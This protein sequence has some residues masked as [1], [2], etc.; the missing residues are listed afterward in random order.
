MKKTILLI[1]VFATLG[2]GVALAEHP[3]EHPAQ[4]AIGDSWFDLE[5]CGMCKNLHNDEEL[6]ENMQW[7]TKLFAQ[8]LIEVTTVPAAYEDR[9]DKLMA[10]MEATGA[11]LM[12]GEKIPLCGMC[13]SYGGLMMAGASMEQMQVGEAH[14]SVISS[15][16]P[17]VI[18]K[19]R[20]H[21]E[22]TIEEMKKWMSEGH[23]NDHGHD[24]HH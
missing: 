7:D 15:A 5:N 12:A 16:D 13:Q 6:F 14:I 23:S 17:A 21:G 22:T 2:C 20:A 11:K 8:G 10:A 18:Q 4:K 9:F 3:T 1:A 24:H 19:I